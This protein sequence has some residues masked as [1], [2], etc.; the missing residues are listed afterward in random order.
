MG[1]RTRQEGS[2]KNRMGQERDER[3]EEE[4]RRLR[5]FRMRRAGDSK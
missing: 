1:K 4:V 5:S 2:T 3:G